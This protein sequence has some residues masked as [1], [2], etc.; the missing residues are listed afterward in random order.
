MTND[1]IQ[2]VLAMAGS[3]S[4]DDARGMARYV[5]EAASLLAQIAKSGG[6]I[7]IADEASWELIQSECRWQEFNG[8]NWYEVHPT[9]LRLDLNGEDEEIFQRVS[10]AVSYLTSRGLLVAHPDNATLVRQKDPAS[11]EVRG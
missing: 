8:V 2:R 6:A 10:E 9:N 4:K 1:H 3:L 11:P 5:N 7:S